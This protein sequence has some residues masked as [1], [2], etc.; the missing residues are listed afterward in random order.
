MTSEGG[1]IAAPFF[2]I[3]TDNGRLIS[4]VVLKE[5]QCTSSSWRTAPAS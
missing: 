4:C 5:H 2:L 3:P 1:G